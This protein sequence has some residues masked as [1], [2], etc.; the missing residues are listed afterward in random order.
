MAKEIKKQINHNLV[1]TLS[2]HGVKI[3]DANTVAIGE[4]FFK[5][6]NVR[7]FPSKVDYEWLTDVCNLNN[8]IVTISCEKELNTESI[9]KDLSNNISINRQTV[10]DNREASAVIVAQNNILSYETMI[11]EIANNG[12]GIFN[13]S[14]LVA[15]FGNSLDDLKLKYHGVRN[16][17]LGRSFR[18][19]QFQFEQLVAFKSTMPFD[20]CSEK[21]KQQAEQLI[22]ISTLMGGFPFAFAG[23][24]DENGTYFGKDNSGSLIMVDIWKRGNDRLNCNA[25]ILGQAGG[26]KSTAMKHLIINEY[27]QGT[28]IIVIDPQGEYKD[29][30]NALDGD[31]INVCGGE[32]GRINPLHIYPYIDDDDK[33][34]D[35]T[36]VMPDLAKH[37]NKLEV[38]FKLYLDLTPVQLA[39]LEDCIITTYAQKGIVWDTRL[40]LIDESMFPVMSDLY[41]VVIDK[42]KELD[43]K[44]TATGSNEKNYYTDLS[45]M[46]KSIGYGADSFLWNGP[47][48][49]KAT[50]DFIV[51]DTKGIA[52]YNPNKQKALYNNVLT[53]SSNLL[54]KNKSERIILVCDE[55]HY[56][57]D[58]RVP[59]SL[60]QLNKMSKTARKYEGGIWVATQQSIDFLDGS[61]KKEGSALLDQACIKLLMPIGKGQDLKEV[62]N[63][64]SLTDAEEEVLTSQQRGKGLL[65]IGSRRMVANF[66]IPRHHLD[67]IGTGGGK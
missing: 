46:I 51:F 9:M 56:I 18:L 54:Y 36:F 44:K 25:V 52:D 15:V 16:K 2:P 5:F 41:D 26:G 40:Q 7:K 49:I 63:L 13:I 23:I 57:V 10:L 59:E 14:L 38:F 65:T 55:A 48:T 8:T 58:S 20:E 29:M 50:K 28:K 30:C 61:I 67:I 27:I 43:A 66:V 62:K 4:N 6:C 47:S 33:A 12:E 53:Y 1:N 21:V 11:D 64:Y 22:P 42:A 45:Y 19:Q 35:T 37:I 32:G 31:L 24:N 34:D 17:F 60:N 39:V 3:I